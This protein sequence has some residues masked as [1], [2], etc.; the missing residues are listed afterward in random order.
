MAAMP[1]PPTT[2][3]GWVGWALNAPI[4]ELSRLQHVRPLLT[5]SSSPGR[6]RPR[7]QQ[8]DAI[9]VSSPRVLAAPAFCGFPR[10]LP[11]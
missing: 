3:R 11:A 8:G 10:F 1:P 7:L 9:P 2:T 5:S 6:H 4:D